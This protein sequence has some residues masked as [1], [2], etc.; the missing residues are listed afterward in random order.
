MLIDQL[1]E[2][3]L[4]EARYTESTT[5]KNEESRRSVVELLLTRQRLADAAGRILECLVVPEKAGTVEDGDLDLLT[6]ELNRHTEPIRF[7]PEQQAY[8]RKTPTFM[9]AFELLEYMNLCLRYGPEHGICARLECGALMVSGRGA[10]KFCTPECRKAEWAYEHNKTYYQQHRS[11][12]RNHKSTMKKARTPHPKTK[13]P[14]LP[15]K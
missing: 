10:K 12:S 8:R 7:D 6:E 1:L 9:L 11:V 4:E 14:A 5:W 15:Q 2:R 3:V 13:R